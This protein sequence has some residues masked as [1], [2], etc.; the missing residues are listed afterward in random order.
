ME[1]WSWSSAASVAWLAGSLLCLAPLNA[2]DGN[3]FSSALGDGGTGAGQGGQAE[4]E[5]GAPLSAGAPA[6]L[7]GEAPSAAG[8]AGEGGAPTG[9][10]ANP[11]CDAGNFCREGE[12]VSCSDFSDLATLEYDNPEPLEVLNS[13]TNMEGLRFARPS[14]SGDGLLYVREFFGGHLW[15]TSDPTKTAGTALTSPQDVLESGGI[16]VTHPLPKPLAAYNFFFQRRSSAEGAAT[17]LYGAHMDDSGVVVGETELPEPFNSNVNASYSLALSEQ[18]A[19]WMQNVN[20]GLDLHL[21]TLRL[22]PEGAEPADLRLPL[23]FEC[24]FAGEFELAP[25]LT[26]DGKVLFF[27]ARAVDETCVFPDGTATRVYAIALSDLGEPLGPARALSNLG[28][29][30]RRQTDP[31]LSPDSCQ[32]F[33]SGDH[34]EGMGIFRA[35][36]VH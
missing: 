29:A 21:K 8:A 6:Q 17:K 7:G 14:G 10:T 3:E 22:V 26:R 13:T 35:E 1:M 4:G 19:I 24:G 33:F 25:W 18:R 9:C 5:G 36:R 15:F 16:R 2:C 32:L 11:D 28:P 20:G 31:A 34:D 12:C 23:P 27:T 30:E